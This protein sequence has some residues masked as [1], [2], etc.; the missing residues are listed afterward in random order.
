MNPTSSRANNIFITAD[1]IANWTS[2]TDL[3]NKVTFFGG[4][5]NGGSGGQSAA[6]L[7]QG[8]KTA[9]QRISSSPF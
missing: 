9:H 4:G 2:A 3:F 6:S 5:F 7:E 1:V 8:N